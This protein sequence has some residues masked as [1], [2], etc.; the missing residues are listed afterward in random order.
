MPSDNTLLFV[1]PIAGRGRTRRRLAGIVR[2]L[3][4]AGTVTEIRTS[5]A[6]GDL[7]AQ[8]FDAVNA[9][10]SRVL[11]AGGDGSIH[12]AVNGILSANRRAAL[13]VIPTG[14][15]NDFAKACGIPLDWRRA[16]RELATRLR[17]G[18]GLRRVDAGRM[19]GRWFANGAGIGFDAKVTRAAQSCRLPLGGIVYLLTVL[20]CLVD[21][22]TTPRMS[23]HADGVA[24]DDAVTLASIANGPWVGGLFHIAPMAVNNDG[25]FDL[26]IAAPVTRR[27][28]L[29]LLPMLLRGG[30]LGQPEISHFPVS[31][32]TISADADTPSQLDG[33]VQP[34]TREFEIEL[35]S[36]ALDLL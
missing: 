7:E 31:K 26:V 19:N 29:V 20:R 10:A 18:D 15:G 25:V 21:G 11:V 27:R 2:I 3:D 6:I 32:L 1:N 36:G 13:G 8:V 4:A 28:V 5:R 35:L 17:A 14:T 30:H 12:E 9:G 23:I 22:I 16:T 34:L 24:W 33:E